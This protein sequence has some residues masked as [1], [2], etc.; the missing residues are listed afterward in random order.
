MQYR[1]FKAKDVT[2]K[3][4]QLVGAEG[5]KKIGVC[6]F[7]DPECLEQCRIVCKHGSNGVSDMFTPRF[8]PALMRIRIETAAREYLDTTG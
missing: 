8:T 4:T 2:G 7:C 3:L 1:A 6:R 5:A